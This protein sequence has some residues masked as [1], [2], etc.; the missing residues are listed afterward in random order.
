MRDTFYRLTA[1]ILDRIPDISHQP[2]GRQVS[3]GLAASLL[4]HLLLLL[5]AVVFGMVLP[6]HGLLHFA[7]PKPELAEIEI[8]VIP[9]EP[10]PQLAVAPLHPFIDSAGLAAAERALENALFQSDANMVAASQIPARGVLPIPSQD[11]LQIP[12]L[13]MFA[14]Q[15]MSLGKAAEPFSP[16]TPTPPEF[17]QPTEAQVTPPA[18]EPATAPEEMPPTKLKEVEKPA[19]EEIAIA[20]KTT[21]AV[22]T[23]PKMR[24][25]VAMRPAAAP[26]SNNR[27]DS[28]MGYE[29]TRTDGSISEAG[30]NA[31]DAAV[32]PYG[33]YV[34]KMLTAVYSRWVPYKQAKADM[35]SPG[36]VLVVFSVDRN[37]RISNVRSQDNTSTATFATVCEDAVRQTELPPLPAAV[38]DTAIED[39]L[40]ESIRFFSRGLPSQF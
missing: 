19:E 36:S 16:Q 28:R 35:I 37:G 14:D 25:G 31:A 18:P 7:K 11:G 12:D 23:L 29:K 21:K 4:F 33:L 27:P 22:P 26:P 2:K 1:P 17:A 40:D 5:L 13:A 20:K 6:E 38:L 30:P 15:K 39:R 3:I 8:T 34:K 32:T 10:E 24:T 9:P